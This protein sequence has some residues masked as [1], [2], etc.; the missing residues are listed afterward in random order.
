MPSRNVRASSADV[1][2][3]SVARIRA[4]VQTLQRLL[5]DHGIAIPGDADEAA[6]EDEAAA[7][8][9]GGADDAKDDDGV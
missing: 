8:A 2:T 1:T 7:A 6:V 3:A 4:K 9:A 5:A